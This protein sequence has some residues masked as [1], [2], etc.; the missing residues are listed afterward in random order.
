M[1]GTE[2]FLWFILA[3]FYISCLFTVCVLTFRKGHTVLGIVGFFFPILWLIGAFI[4]A[5]QG[6]RYDVEQQTIYQRQ[7]AEYTRAARTPSSFSEAMSST[8]GCWSD[9]HGPPRRAASG[10]TG[11]A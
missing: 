5:K 2:T 7:M 10:S 3:M 6:S 9:R 1:Y 8:A 4:P 11:P